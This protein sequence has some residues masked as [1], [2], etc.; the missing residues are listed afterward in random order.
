VRLTRQ[1]LSVA[2]LMAAVQFFTMTDSMLM[3]PMGPILVQSM[4]IDSS[5]IGYFTGIFVAAACVSGLASSAFLD[6]FDRKRVLLFGL[7]GLSVATAATGLATDFGSIMVARFVAGLFAG[8]TMAVTYAILADHIAEKRRGRA[9]GIVAIAFGIASVM[10]VPV[11]LQLALMFGWPT[12]FAVIGIIGGIIC[13]L[14][15]IRLGNQHVIKDSVPMTAGRA[16]REFGMTMRSPPVRIGL[17][18]MA[19]HIASNMLLIPNMASFMSFNLDYPVEALGVL[20]MAGGVAGI[21]GGNIGGRL[22]DRFGSARILSGNAVLLSMVIIMLWFVYQPGWPVM[23]IFAAFVL[24][25][26]SGSA[27]VNSRV[28]KIPPPEQ[29]GRFSSLQVATQHAS[30]A[31]SSILASVWLTSGPDGQV[32]HM[33]WLA[34]VAIICALAVPALITSLDSLTQPQRACRSG[35]CPS[36]STTET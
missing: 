2:C 30:T 5:A 20:W 32:L 19:L 34:I 3:I 9:M 25:N 18:A 14:L 35:I 27:I 6:R 23:P 28:S 4:G 31:I 26:L 15:H 7:T 29:R 33:G 11:G 12:S 1:E 24:L 17:L 22:A 21:L 36:I 13:I 16:F 8:P 10:G